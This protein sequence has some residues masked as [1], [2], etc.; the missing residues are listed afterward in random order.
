MEI[1]IGRQ[2]SKVAEYEIDHNE[3][4]LTVHIDKQEGTVKT[5][6]RRRFLAP[7]VSGTVTELYESAA[8]IMQAEAT[9]LRRPLRY[10]LATRNNAMKAWAESEERG[11]R[12]F[13]W[14]S[15]VENNGTL[16]AET[17][18]QPSE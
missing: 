2:D 15:V 11:R 13:D 10:I 8:T 9:E 4:K 12:I 7:R 18:I 1:S 14:E 3:T 17:V 6:I 5:E 16:V